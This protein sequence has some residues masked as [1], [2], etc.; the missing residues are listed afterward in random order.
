[1]PKKTKE[2]VDEY[3]ARGGK[4]QHIPSGKSGLEDQSPKERSKT[5]YLRNMDKVSNREKYLEEREGN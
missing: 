1:M 2:T 5:D 3:L 4:I